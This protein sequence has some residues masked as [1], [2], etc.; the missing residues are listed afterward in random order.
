MVPEQEMVGAPNIG[1]TVLNTVIGVEGLESVQ[2]AD[3]YTSS[4]KF[5]DSLRI[6][7]A[8]VG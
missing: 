6:Y 7:S 4:V 2:M 3:R 8:V 5:E 1:G